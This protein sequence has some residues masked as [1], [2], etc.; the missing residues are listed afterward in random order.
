MSNRRWLALISLALLLGLVAC[1][2]GTVEPTATPVPT[3]M[4]SPTESPDDDGTPPVTDADREYMRWLAGV[5]GKLEDT[6]RG[7]IERWQASEEAGADKVSSDTIREMASLAKTLQDYVDEVEARED[8]PV[9][10]AGIHVALLNEAHSWE[11]AA[12]LLVEGI[13]ALRDGD[14]AGFQEKAEEADREIQA[15]V[16][17]REAL[18]E[19]ANELLRSLSEAGGD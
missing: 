19:A 14:Q 18:L 6:S 4:P 9:G 5:H 2:S 17:A 10:V 15:A 1:A 12:P 8:V 7:L 13:T 3:S 11:A 16:E